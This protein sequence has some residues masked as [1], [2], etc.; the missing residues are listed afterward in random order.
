MQGFRAIFAAQIYKKSSQD[1]IPKFSP[2]ID[3]GEIILRINMLRRFS[4]N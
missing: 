2:S 1:I 3:E 4:N